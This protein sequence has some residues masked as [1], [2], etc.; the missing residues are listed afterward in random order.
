MLTMKRSVYT[1][2]KGWAREH[3][4]GTL[5]LYID[6]TT[7]EALATMFFTELQPRLL[8]TM[9]IHSLKRLDLNPISGIL[10]PYFSRCFASSS[11]NGRLRKLLHQWEENRHTGL[12]HLFIKDLR[13]LGCQAPSN[14]KGN[15]D[16]FVIAHVL[17]S[18]MVVAF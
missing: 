7:E 5:E 4:P 14:S 18:G 11:T 2:V 12:G 17:H 8:D 16:P 1:F 3:S 10:L 13:R 6:C 9:L 15:K